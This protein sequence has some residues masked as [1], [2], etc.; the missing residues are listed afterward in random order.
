MLVSR[1]RL[2]HVNEK[3]VHVK[4][5]ICPQPVDGIFTWLLVIHLE[6]ALNQPLQAFVPLDSLKWR[7]Y[8]LG[9]ETMWATALVFV[10]FYSLV[11]Y[12][13]RAEAYFIN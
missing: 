12:E 11:S 1:T 8:L 7:L 10:S 9:G 5:S 6:R 3:L 4:V 13:K 2:L